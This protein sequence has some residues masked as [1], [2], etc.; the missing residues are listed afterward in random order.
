MTHIARLIAVTAGLLLVASAAVANAVGLDA[1]APERHIVPEDFQGWAVVHFGVAGAPPLRREEDA[2][3]MEY[4]ATGR[5]E[6]STPAP[7][8]EGFIQRG[9]YRQMADGLAPM[10]RVGDIWGEYTHLVVPDDR[11]GVV[12]RSSGFFVGTMKEFL[13]TEWP[14]E[15]RAPIAEQD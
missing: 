2:L 8:D 5:L 3:I 7:D 9:Y 6:T 4:P 1:A 15:H 11:D 12:F 10:S 13:A 14:A